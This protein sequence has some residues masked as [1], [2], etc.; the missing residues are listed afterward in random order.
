MGIYN[1]H[2]QTKQKLTF[3]LAGQVVSASA[4]AKKILV[5]AIHRDLAWLIPQA[6]SVLKQLRANAQ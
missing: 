6:E 5:N 1:L 4:H 3:A 2:M